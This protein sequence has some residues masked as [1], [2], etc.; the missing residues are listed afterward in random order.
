MLGQLEQA[1]QKWGGAH[2]VID[3][4]LQERQKL[5]VQYCELAGLPPFE[6]NHGALPEPKTIRDFCQR[7]V[8]YVSSGHFEV[9]EKITE[10][11]NNDEQYNALTEHVYP[12]INETTQHALSFNDDFAEIENESQMQNFDAKLSSLGQELEQRF[13]LE[14]QLISSL[15]GEY[16]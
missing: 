3:N 1:Q 15:H 13:E 10:Q 14:D 7:L 2:S 4:W 12:T 5:L 11:G 8:D 16:L 6:R 9:Y